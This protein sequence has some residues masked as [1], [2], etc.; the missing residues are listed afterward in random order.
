MDRRE[1]LKTAGLGAAA[2]GLASCGGK[3]EQK[4]Q[5]VSGTMEYRTD[6]NTGA[7][8]SLLGYGCMRWLM[9]KDSEGNDIVDQESVNALVDRAIEMGVNYFD[10]APVYL[11]GLSERATATALLRHPRDSYY[12]ATKL[13]RFDDTSFERSV[14]MYQASL[15]NYETDHIDYYLLH[16]LNGEASFKSRFLDNGLMDYLLKERE[17]GHIRNLGFS[18][19]GGREGFD[20]LLAYHEKY[21]WDFVQIQM[22]YVDWN[23]METKTNARRKEANA[24]YLYDEL[25]KR[26]IPVVIMEPLLGGRLAELPDAAMDR[27]SGQE[28]G[29][30]AASWA[31]RFTGSYPR[32]LTIL[33]GMTYMEHLEDNLKTFC[34]FQP[35][36]EKEMSILDDVAKL[37]ATY[38]TVDCTACQYCMP[39]PYGINIPGIFS[40]YNKCV[41]EGVMPDPKAELRDSEDRKAFKKAR[42]EFLLGYDRAIPSIRQADHCIGCG[43]CLEKCPQSIDIPRQLQRIDRY[44]NN[45]KKTF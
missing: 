30:S 19:H 14:A 25:D 21:H 28:A 41:N 31:F 23:Y 8:I 18:F 11:R 34:G 3:S 16:G 35:L 27:L 44:V 15:R 13:S 33:S 40:H 29:R 36:N 10:S 20:E 26:E 6:P 4:R 32:V 12:I 9:T 5:G 38:D 45:L 39:C 37:L 43:Q 42:R 22:N 24:S 17:A 7:Q 1:F 2:L